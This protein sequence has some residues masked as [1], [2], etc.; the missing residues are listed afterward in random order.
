GRRDQRGSVDESDRA[1]LLVL[2]GKARTD[3]EGDRRSRRAL[4]RLQRDVSGRRYALALHEVPRARVSLV[5]AALRDALC[6]EVRAAG[7]PETG[8]GDG[9]RAA[10]T[11]RPGQTKR[12]G[13]GTYV[14]GRLSRNR[15]GRFRLLT[16]PLRASR[17]PRASWPAPVRRRARRRAP[18]P[19]NASLPSS[20]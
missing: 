7:I 14:R 6:P 13:R 9:A 1:G 3:R 10:G 12:G 4:R 5:A 17:R 18:S 20:A 2:P 19:R 16:K 15:A 11:I 8:S